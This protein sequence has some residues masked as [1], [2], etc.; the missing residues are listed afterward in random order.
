MHTRSLVLLAGLLLFSSPA[1]AQDAD[2]AP[3]GAWYVVSA[4]TRFAGTPWGLQGEVQ[5]RNHAVFSDLQQA[6]ARGGVEAHL[7]DGSATFVLSY[8]YLYSEA[9]GTPDLPFYEHRVHQE[10]SLRQQVWRLR[11]G[12]RFRFEERFVEGSD[13]QGRYRYALS[14]TL[15][16]TT[17]EMQ[18]GTFY[19]AASNE[20]FLRGF[21]RGDRPVFDRD[22]V[23]GALGYRVS[24]VV[25]VQAGYLD[26]LFADDSDGQIHLSL[27]LSL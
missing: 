26:Q 4:N 22:R 20:V 2:R 12:H 14:A 6:L 27:R 3:F 21:G 7:A 18:D 8:G 17:R 16:L 15:P 19:A 24:P 5:L 9:E 23:Y 13:A 1:L 11:V 10:V 25:S